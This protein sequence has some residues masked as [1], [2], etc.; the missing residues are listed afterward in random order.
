MASSISP[1]ASDFPAITPLGSLSTKFV[2]LSN[3]FG[4]SSC[5][6]IDALAASITRASRSETIKVRN[7]YFLLRAGSVRSKLIG[8]K[9]NQKN[10]ATKISIVH[11]IGEMLFAILSEWL[12]RP[13]LNRN[14]ESPIALG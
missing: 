7:H 1:R 6:T 5:N 3:T 12:Y 14:P 9:E 2:T 4:L 11:R 8:G 13:S 10:A